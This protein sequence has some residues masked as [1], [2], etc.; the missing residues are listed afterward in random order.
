M[1]LIGA[2][3]RGFDDAAATMANDVYAFAVLA[4][5]VRIRFA[6]FLDEPLNGFHS[7]TGFRWATS[8]PRR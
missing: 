4:W 2:R 8:I 6:A 3:R 7:W 5:E 1:E